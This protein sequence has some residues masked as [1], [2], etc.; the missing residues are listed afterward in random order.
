MAGGF[1]VQNGEGPG[2]IPFKLEEPFFRPS[3]P[4]PP[5]LSTFRWDYS[6]T[7][8]TQSSSGPITSDGGHLCKVKSGTFVSL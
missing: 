7:A 3:R 1:P 4:P 2:R 5:P 6:A 8:L